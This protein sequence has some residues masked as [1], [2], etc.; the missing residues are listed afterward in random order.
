MG[1][2]LFLW[3]FFGFFLV[4][5]RRREQCE[6][7]LRRK[8]WG[9]E[10]R[11]LFLCVSLCGVQCCF[12]HSVNACELVNCGGNL[13]HLGQVWDEQSD[14]LVVR[15]SKQ[16]F[17]SPSEACHLQLDLSSIENSLLSIREDFK[18]FTD[19]KKR[20]NSGKHCQIRFLLFFKEFFETEHPLRL[21]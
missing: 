8:Y 13:R 14:T 16:L 3:G 10:L 20:R 9:N 11:F 15:V 17:S 18:S 12:L 6:G 19:S 1:F 4:V 21:M 7:K 5:F 2:F